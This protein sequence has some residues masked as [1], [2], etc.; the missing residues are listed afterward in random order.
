M[1]GRL[2]WHVT[3]LVW[4]L[5]APVAR[6]AAEQRA[7]A[8]LDPHERQLLD[9]YGVPPDRPRRVPPWLVGAVASVL[10][11]GCGWERPTRTALDVAAHA[12]VAVD[13]DLAPRY[14]AAA[15]EALEASATRDEYAGR[16]ERWDRAEAALGYGREALLLAEAALDAGT[17]DGPGPIVGCIAV[18]L[19]RIRD[20]LAD[21]GVEAPGD[22]D[23]ALGLLLG[24]ASASC[25]VQP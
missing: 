14:E 8:E 19:A 13:V 18:A 21:L 16:M 17:A 20:V 3:R 23:R 22:L 12:L 25:E 9:D 7:D 1:I 2:L 4:G 5:P 11:L 24:I 15:A 10:V 6:A